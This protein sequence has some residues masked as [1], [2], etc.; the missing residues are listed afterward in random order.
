MDD[1][2]HWHE[3]EAAAAAVNE[4]LRNELQPGTGGRARATIGIGI[5][6]MVSVVTNDGT[7]V[8]ATFDA[9]EKNKVTLTPQDDGKPRPYLELASTVDLTRANG[10]SVKAQV[11]DNR[12][13]K[14]ILRT[15]PV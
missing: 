14:L 9:A 4:R 1:R 7:T 12:R 10:E 13:G 5:G 3:S 2:G 15:L 8:M 11:W 6:E